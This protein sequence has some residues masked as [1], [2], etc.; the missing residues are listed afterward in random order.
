MLWLIVL[1]LDRFLFIILWYTLIL[2]TCNHT[3]ARRHR[4]VAVEDQKW[5]STWLTLKQCIKWSE[6]QKKLSIGL[7]RRR[8]TLAAYGHVTRYMPL[9]YFYPKKRKYLLH[10]VMTTHSLKIDTGTWA[11]TSERLWFNKARSLKCPLFWGSLIKVTHGAVW[12]ACRFNPCISTRPLTDKER[13]QSEYGIVLLNYHAVITYCL[14]T[15]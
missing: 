11:E 3:E 8:I 5:Q 13:S 15:W 1:K 10:M 6:D 12:A 7:V 9:L 14:A 2:L 4:P